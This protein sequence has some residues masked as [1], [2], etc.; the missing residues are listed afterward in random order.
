[1]KL[2]AVTWCKESH[3]LYDYS[4]RET[5]KEKKQIAS[6]VTQN[7]EVVRTDASNVV[8]LISP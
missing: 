3:G 7:Q 1:M 2:Q 5:H 8:E 6:F 4:T